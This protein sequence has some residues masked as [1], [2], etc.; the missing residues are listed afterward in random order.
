MSTGLSRTIE[1]K[2]R[3]VRQ[4]EKLT[5]R[6][7][8]IDSKVEDAALVSHNGAT[9][10]RSDD[11]ILLPLWDTTALPVVLEASEHNLNHA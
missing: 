1:A 10:A 7:S 4:A 3:K 5:G 6:Q 8:C 2:G 9:L 11:G